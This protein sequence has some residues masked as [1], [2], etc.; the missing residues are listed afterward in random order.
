M[1]RT[2]SRALLA[3]PASATLLALL[4]ACS[5]EVE[6][7]T[8][9]ASSTQAPSGDQQ[10]GEMPGGGGTTGEIAAV[11][12]LLMQV[13]GDDGQTAVSWDDSTTITQTVAGTLADV[14][15]GSCVVAM[16][17]SEDGTAATSVTV[18]AATDGE[19]TSGFGGG[20]SG[21]GMP[22]GSGDDSGSGERPSGMPSGAPDGE[23]PEGGEMPDGAPT[24]LPD[25]ASGGGFGGMSAGLVTAVDGSTIT[26][27]QIGEDSSTTATITVDDATTYTTT[28]TADS[29]AVVVG[30]CVTAIGE[31]DSSGQVAAGCST[32]FGGGMPG[33]GR[34]GSGQGGDSADQG[35][36]QG[37]DGSDA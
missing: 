13:Q 32:G 17:A 34:G 9:E 6:T 35:S 24:D 20:G 5:S 15:V 12:D 36:G 18:T 7:A 28:V 4:V 31:A 27:Q 37:E 3:L 14:T 8:P 21:G 10:S 26:V 25:G 33:G 11:S 30:L 16:G 23:M 2:R 22:G 1:S 19:C 29:S